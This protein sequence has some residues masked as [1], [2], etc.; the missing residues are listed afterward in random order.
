M[1]RILCFLRGGHLARR[2]YNACYFLTYSCGRCGADLSDRIVR[3][4]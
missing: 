3:L 4:P 2:G 1:K